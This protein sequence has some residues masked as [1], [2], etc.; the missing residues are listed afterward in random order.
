[1]MQ[2]VYQK[3]DFGEQLRFDPSKYQTLSL[4]IQ[5]S[6][7]DNDPFVTYHTSTH[8]ADVVQS[9]YYYMLCAGV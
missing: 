6:Y 5:A 7:R 9:V 1:M 4:K 2:Y 3:F 8:A